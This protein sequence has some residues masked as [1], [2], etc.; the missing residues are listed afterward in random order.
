M[1]NKQYIMKK[2]TIHLKFREKINTLSPS[3]LRLNAQDFKEKLLSKET[4]E[5]EINSILSNSHGFAPCFIVWNAIKYMHNEQSTN[6][7]IR[8]WGEVNQ[9]T[10]YYI[11]KTIN[12]LS[13]IYYIYS[14]CTH[15]LF[16]NLA[17]V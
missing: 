1:T 4:T 15:T 2:I 3:E 14:C 16:I 13:T 8:V 5:L 11:N 12:E 6:G 7:T 9:L 10:Q 17:S